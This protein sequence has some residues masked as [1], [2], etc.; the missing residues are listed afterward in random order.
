[1]TKPIPDGFHTLTPHLI[2]PDGAEAIEFY[3]KALGAQEHVR[4]L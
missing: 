1:M 3:Q 2:V 4:H